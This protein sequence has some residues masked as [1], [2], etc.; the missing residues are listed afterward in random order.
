MDSGTMK[1]SSLIGRLAG[2]FLFG[3][4]LFLA[5]G[6]VRAAD[7]KLPAIGS[8][9]G[10]WIFDCRAVRANETLC[11]LT[12]TRLIKETGKRVLQ[13]SIGPASP[14][15]K[16]ALVVEVPLGIFLPAGVAAKIDEGKQFPLALQTCIP[17]GC[18][19]IML[20]PDKKLREMKKGKNL[21]IG[22]KTD[23]RGE[24][25][26]IAASLKGITK[27]LRVLKAANKR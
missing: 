15:G 4:A 10:E 25:I 6:E 22:F 5:A 12:Q 7:E 18:E 23:M 1:Y 17:R 27:G 24:T 3:G 26:S 13:V 9:I 19:A 20:I 8:K 16:L 14:N 11:R 2:A 21:L